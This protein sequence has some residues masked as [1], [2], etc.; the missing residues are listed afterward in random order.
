MDHDIANH[1]TLVVWTNPSLSLNEVQTANAI[2]LKMPD[3]I[4][5]MSPLPPS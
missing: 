3:Q 2:L 4:Y 1:M 5:V